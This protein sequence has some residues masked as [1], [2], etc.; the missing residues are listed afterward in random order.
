MTGQGGESAGPSRCEPS[1]W[2]L[3]LKSL[4]QLIHGERSGREVMTTNT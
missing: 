2:G 3:C 1:P 4:T